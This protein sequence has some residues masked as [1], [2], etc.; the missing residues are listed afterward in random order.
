M[1]T[2][3]QWACEK[4]DDFHII[5]FLILSLNNNKTRISFLTTDTG[6]WTA[7][8]KLFPALCLVWT[9]R[10]RVLNALYSI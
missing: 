1:K 2:L 4:A 7:V 6:Q 8:L 5:T 9:H 3:W 10:N